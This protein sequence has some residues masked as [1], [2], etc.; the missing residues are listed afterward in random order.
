MSASA[1][2][3][4]ASSRLVLASDLSARCDRAQ[5]RAAQLTSQWSWSLTVV[6]A[7]DSSR[8]DLHAFSSPKTPTWRRPES[9]VDTLTA[10]LRADLRHDGLEPELVVQQTDN[11]AKLVLET[12]SHPDVGLVVSGVAR[13]EPLLTLRLGHLVDALMRESRVPVLTVRRRVRGPYQRIVVASDFSEASGAALDTTLRLFPS[14]RITVFHAHSSPGGRLV[15]TDETAWQEAAHQQY[16]RFVQSLPL[17]PED[18]ARLDFVTEQG[19][20]ESLLADYTRHHDID[21]VALGTHGR[22][23]WVRALLGST[24]ANL[25]QALACDTLLVRGGD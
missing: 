22:S 15:T 13:D 3:S 23:G 11:P 17:R 9:W 12:A 14:G 6:H 18:A 1:V 19:Y 20:P 4:S 5:D 21:L 16:A 8:V 10:R 25:M 24:A 2:P 7:I